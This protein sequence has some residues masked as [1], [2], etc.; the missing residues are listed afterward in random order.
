MDSVQIQVP[1]QNTVRTACLSSCVSTT[2]TAVQKLR[3]QVETKNAGNMN[4]SRTEQGRLLRPQHRHQ[5]FSTSALLVN[6]HI[7]AKTATVVVVST[8]PHCSYCTPQPDHLFSSR[9][10]ISFTP[11][12]FRQA[13]ASRVSTSSSNPRPTATFIIDAIV[14]VTLRSVRRRIA[15]QVSRHGKPGA[16]TCSC[17]KAICYTYKHH[18]QR[19]GHPSRSAHR[20]AQANP[21]RPISQSSG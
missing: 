11:E 17:W 5:H 7:D 3:W 15:T 19:R 21:A 8:S 20:L 14:H 1:D 16:G 2:G 12:H 9:N 13:G 18:Q 6:F 4:S 10:R